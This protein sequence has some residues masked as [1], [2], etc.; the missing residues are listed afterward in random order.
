MPETQDPLRSL[1]RQAAETVGRR[2]PRPRRVHHRTGPVARRRRLALTGAAA[3]L[4]VGCG[5]ATAFQL[6]PGT[7]ASTVP[8]T[9]PV[10]SGA[11]PS[12]TTPGGASPDATASEE[13]PSPGRGHGGTAADGSRSTPTS[14]PPTRNPRPP[15]PPPP[16]RPRP[17]PRRVPPSTPRGRPPPVGAPPRPRDTDTRPPGARPAAHAPPPRAHPSAH[18]R[19]RTPKENGLPA[20]SPGVR[21]SAPDTTTWPVLSPDPSPPLGPT[22]QAGPR[23][24]RPGEL[25]GARGRSRDTR[26]SA[27]VGGS[28]AHVGPAGRVSES[29]HAN[30]RPE[31][32]RRWWSGRRRGAGGGG[33]AGPSPG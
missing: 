21:R 27:A 20:P 22:P 32:V 7:S 17:T 3:C 24:D 6:L 2:H 1:F 10:P 18:T 13:S 15:G 14:P 5:L 8:A 23:R 33:E 31:G 25:P 9:S 12:A 16:R 19:P 26:G 11:A 30:R 4:V 29:G 28:D